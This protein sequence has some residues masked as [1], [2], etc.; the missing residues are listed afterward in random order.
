[1]SVK[2]SPTEEKYDSYSLEVLAIVKALEKY[3]HYLLG[4]KFKVFTDCEAFK[5]TMD[6]V[7]VVA[8]VARWMMAMQ[9]FDFEVE[10]RTNAQM[11]HVDALSRVNTIISSDDNLC[12]KVRKMQQK[13][14]DLTR[15][16]ALLQHQEAYDN[17]LL[18]NDIL[19]RIINGRELLVVPKAMEMEIIKTAHENGH[20]GVKKVEEEI[21]QQFFIKKAKEKIQNYVGSCIKCILAERK[22]GRSEGVLHPIDKGDSRQFGCG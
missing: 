17:Y 12:V 7:N 1:M 13:D 10:H 18:R 5:K 4:V 11:R 15:V 3:R 8:K 19:Y 6:K 2:T 14:D 16:R 22:H 20:F 9:E 21:G